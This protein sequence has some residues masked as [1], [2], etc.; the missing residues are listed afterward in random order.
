V[1]LCLEGY[2]DGTSIHRIIKQF[3]VQMG[4]PTGTGKGGESI[5][6]R[7]FK[8][9]IHGRIKFNHRGQ[10]AMANENAPHTNQS[11]FFITLGACEWLNKKHTIFGKVTGN[12][13]FNVLRIGDADTNEQDRPLEPITVVQTEVLMNP[14]DDIIPRDL[15][16]KTI[17]NNKDSKQP[18]TETA[19]DK[20]KV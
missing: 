7:P 9:E 12:T 18:P 19:K 3:M 10:V 8:D 15:S 5:W 1:Q 14:F 4:D 16:K 17:S 2:Y 20:I 6:G 13:I 11:Q